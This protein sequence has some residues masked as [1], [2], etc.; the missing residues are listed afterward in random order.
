LWDIPGK[1]S[2]LKTHIDR[3]AII[4]TKITWK[5]A[6]LT[7]TKIHRQ[8]H[9]IEKFSV[10]IAGHNTLSPICKKSNLN[11]TV[12][13]CVKTLK[14]LGFTATKGNGNK[15]PIQSLTKDKI[16]KLQNLRVI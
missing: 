10:F 16:K 11:L 9:L 5:K 12:F 13:S 6:G 3:Y 14:S 7:K 15:I 1:N 4:A 8:P 2:S